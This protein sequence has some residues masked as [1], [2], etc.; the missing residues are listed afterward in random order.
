MDDGS[1]VQSL[2]LYLHLDNL[3]YSCILFHHFPGKNEILQI[4]CLG[5]K[6]EGNLLTIAMMCPRI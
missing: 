6:H 3:E 5:T 2:G 4:I 1:N